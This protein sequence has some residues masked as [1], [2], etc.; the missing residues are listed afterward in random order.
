[1]PQRMTRL[2]TSPKINPEEFERLIKEC[3]KDVDL[4]MLRANLRLTV[5]ERLVQ[6][7]S[8]MCA[9]DE[10]RRAVRTAIPVC[11]SA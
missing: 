4:G 10:L 11:V 7:Q 5:E 9:M 2:T 1:M 8:Y 6:L 3:R